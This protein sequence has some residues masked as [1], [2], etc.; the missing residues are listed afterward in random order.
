MSLDSTDGHYDRMTIALHWITAAL[1]VVLWIFGQT[2][3][4]FPRGP[5]RT[6]VWS[7]HVTLGFALALV[8]IF[9][10]FWRA[11]PGRA[12][13][14]ADPGLLHLIA[15]VTH[16]LLYLLLGVAVVLGIANAFVRGYNLF[17]LWTLPQLGDPALRRP[18][19]GWH[20]LAANGIMIV[21]LI[22]AGA[23]LMHHYLWKDGVLQ[24]MAVPRRG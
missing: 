24:R 10:V 18:I 6:G 3:D 15:K 9:R 1:V 8:L 19:T 16:Y 23:A 22:H 4:L 21:A 5:L 20:E 7:L 11:G 12:L 2:A 13:P 14:A 17:G